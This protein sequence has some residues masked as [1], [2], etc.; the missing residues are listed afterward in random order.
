MLELVPEDRRVLA[1]SDGRSQ[2]KAL[3]EAEAGGYE[4]V[5]R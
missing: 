4:G 2:L 1:T 3:I 5:T